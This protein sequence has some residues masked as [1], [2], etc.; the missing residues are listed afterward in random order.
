ML[1]PDDKRNIKTSTKMLVGYVNFVDEFD[2][3]N[4]VFYDAN[5]YYCTTPGPRGH[6]RKFLDI[7]AD[8]EKF[9]AR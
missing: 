9:F 5:S 1:Y 6:I 7:M 4:N 8:D 3:I 2:Y